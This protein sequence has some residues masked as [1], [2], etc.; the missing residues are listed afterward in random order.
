MRKRI[1]SNKIISTF[2]LLEKIFQEK[3]FP[4]AVH[5]EK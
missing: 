5:D 3:I 4:S 1:N 2:I